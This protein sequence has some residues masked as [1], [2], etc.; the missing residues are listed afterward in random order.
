MKGMQKIKRGDNFRG[1]LDYAFDRDKNEEKA[2]GV[3]VGGNMAGTNAKELTAEFLRFADARKDI[4]KPVWHNSLRLPE[5]EDLTDEQWNKIGFDYMERMDFD[6]NLNQFVFI[7]HDDKEG[8]HIHIIGSRIDMLGN[9]HL[10]RNE[11][12]ISTRIISELEIEHNLTQTTNIDYTKDDQ[13]NYSIAERSTGRGRTLSRA[14]EIMQDRKQWNEDVNY[15]APKQRLANV[16]TAAL[17]N[18][19]TT[20]QFI[21]TLEA[22]NIQVQCVVKKGQ[23]VGFSFAIDGENFKGSQVGA[24]WKDITNERKLNYEQERDA[25]IIGSRRYV[26]SNKRTTSNESTLNSDSKPASKSTKEPRK[27][28]AVA[29]T[30]N[31]ERDARGRFISVGEPTNN[32]GLDQGQTRWVLDTRRELEIPSIEIDES[33]NNPT[34]EPET[35]TL[36]DASRWGIID[37]PSIHEPR[38]DIHSGPRPANATSGS[39]TV[40]ESTV[41]TEPTTSSSDANESEQAQVANQEW[42]ARRER[43]LNNL[44]SKG[45]TREQAEYMFDKEQAQRRKIV[46][47]SEKSHAETWTPDKGLD[48]RLAPKQEPVFPSDDRDYETELGAFVDKQKAKRNAKANGTYISNDD[49]YAIG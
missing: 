47:E 28:R 4:K 41:P 43:S 23:M 1:V 5:G 42:L 9:V 18:Q 13:G 45:F 15:L 36:D 21:N 14:E 7:K 6:Q 27:Q 29:D 3:I 38:I 12:L 39:S 33:N 37:S 32:M 19:P 25:E 30:G 49:D 17:A 31:I 34:Q 40:D 16:V 44:V 26:T 8:K 20:E 24:N 22:Q 10:G 48:E 11:N 46:A 35:K 2:N